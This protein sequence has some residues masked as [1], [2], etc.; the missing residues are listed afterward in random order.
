MQNRS[1]EPLS[2]QDTRIFGHDAKRAPDGSIMAQGKGSPSQ[3]TQQHVDALRHHY[4]EKD[5]DEVIA[6]AEKALADHRGKHG[7]T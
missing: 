1:N 5:R 4:H 3:P 2:V 7:R 6:A